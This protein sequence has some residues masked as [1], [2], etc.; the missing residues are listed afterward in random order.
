MNCHS[1]ADCRTLFLHSSFFTLHLKRADERIHVAVG[2]VRQE[3]SPAHILAGSIN[4]DASIRLPDIV[5]Q[6]LEPGLVVALLQVYL[7]EEFQSVARRTAEGKFQFE[8]LLHHFIVDE[9]LLQFLHLVFT[10]V[11]W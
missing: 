2:V 10:Y 5:L 6:C 9:F 4:L 1:P 7:Y 3:A 8:V 11:V